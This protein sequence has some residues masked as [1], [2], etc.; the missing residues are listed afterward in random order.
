[1]KKEALRASCV[2]PS[3]PH[4][5]YC[6][7]L[8]GAQ[9]SAFTGGKA[10]I[11]ANVGANFTAWD[12]YITG[13]NIQLDL[14]RRIIQSWRTSEFPKGSPDSRLEIHFEPVFDGTRVTILHSDIPEGQGEKYRAGWNDKYFQ[15]MR[16]YF[17]KMAIKADRAS[18]ARMQQRASEQTIGFDDEQEEAPKAKMKPRKD[19]PP[20]RATSSKTTPSI[21]NSKSPSK[22]APKPVAAKRAPALAPPPKAAPAPV[23]K[24]AAKAPATQAP[25]AAPKSAT[26]S[27]SKPATKPAKPATKPA[28][29]A[30]KPAAKKPAPKPTK[31]AKSAPKKKKKK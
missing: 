28:K 4:A 18:M 25:T 24:S 17:G 15:P 7:W 20:A 14:G 21:P 8:D 6:A 22:A 26:K 27:A 19:L 12:G 23:P 16:A 3:T 1:M 2:V 29:P 9:H 30:T 5:V 13:K 10:A 31:P 11:N